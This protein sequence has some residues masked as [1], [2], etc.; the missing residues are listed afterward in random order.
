[1]DYGFLS[2]IFSGQNCGCQIL[3]DQLKCRTYK[4]RI[5][6]ICTGPE[7]VSFLLIYHKSNAMFV[8]HTRQLRKRNA[9]LSFFFWRPKEI[10]WGLFE[11]RNV[12]YEKFAWSFLTTSLSFFSTFFATRKIEIYFSKDIHFLYLH[13]LYII[14][15]WDLGVHILKSGP[16]KITFGAT[17][18]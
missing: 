18:S 14:N 15:C 11:M 6:A 10:W 13:I 8:F 3:D 1:M 16:P 12:S 5:M 7:W 17:Y 2:P 9:P 4:F